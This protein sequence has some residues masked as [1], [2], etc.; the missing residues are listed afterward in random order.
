MATPVL[1][2][3]GDRHVARVGAS[4]LN[5]INLNEFVAESLDDYINKAVDLACELFGFTVGFE[6]TIT[7]TNARLQVM[8]CRP[9]AHDV[10][11][12]YQQMWDQC[13]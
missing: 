5:R 3:L 12:A 8:R 4:L 1:T 9:F 13:I 6:T 2:V 11:N 7:A 10:E